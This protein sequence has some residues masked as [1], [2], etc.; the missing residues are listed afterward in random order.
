[1]SLDELK[2]R[3]DRLDERRGGAARVLPGT[4]VLDIEGMSPEERERLRAMLLAA[5]AASDMVDDTP[6]A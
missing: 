6:L 1:M 2:R 5:K 3:V 4:V